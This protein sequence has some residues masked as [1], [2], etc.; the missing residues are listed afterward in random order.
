[1]PRF[2]VWSQQQ[3]TKVTSL[4]AT[5]AFVLATDTPE[6]KAIEV[7]DLSASLFFP[8]GAAR[9]L[10]S[11]GAFLDGVNGLV[12]QPVA[13]NFASTPDAAALDIT[14]D[15][16]I[17][18]KVTMTDWTPTSQKYVVSKYQT[19]T[20]RSY[21]LIVATNGRLILLTSPDGTG[22]STLFGQSTVST[23]V[24]DGD[25]KWVRATLDVNNGSS[26]KV[27]KFYTSDD[28][29]T[30]TQLGTTVTSAGTTSIFNSN[31]QLEVGSF[32]AAASATAVWDGIIHRVIIQSAF[33]TVDNTTSVVFDADFAAQTADA[34][35]FAESSTNAATVTINT[36]RYTYGTPGAGFTTVSTQSVTA[37]T[38]F[39][40]P[41]IITAPTVVDLLA[42]EVTT[43]P[44]ST[45]TVHGAIYA[46]DDNFQPTGAPLAA[47]G[48]VSVATSTTGVYATQITPVTLQ[49]GTYVLGFNTSV[50]F[51]ARS[52]R[53]Q[54]AL[55]HTLGAN[56]VLLTTSA[57]RTNAAFPNPSTGWNTRAASSVGRNTFSFLRWR[58]A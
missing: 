26:Q 33:D 17:K 51:T 13:G 6:A 50:V 53:Q 8:G 4:N 30:W 11:A 12:L 22:A 23:G 31:S 35:A 38:D 5:D 14:G 21:S 47:F 57:T 27:Y 45:A 2:S 1:M 7:K 48:G 25:T 41:F 29:T 49:P 18:A 19:D 55:I 42:W 9:P 46:A 54:A 34:L 37:N 58:P 36:T 20:Q 24:A 16:D 40:E 32:Q 44:A 52:A 3:L 10:L 15:I 28:G 39:F 43:A 56:P